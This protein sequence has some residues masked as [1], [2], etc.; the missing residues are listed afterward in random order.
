MHLLFLNSLFFSSQE[1]G[2]PPRQGT[3]LHTPHISN[4]VA[5]CLGSRMGLPKRGV[6]RPKSV[7]VECQK[8]GVKNVASR[9]VGSPVLSFDTSTLFEKLHFKWKYRLHMTVC[10]TFF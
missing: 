4:T 8:S 3:G 10:F 5:Y 2:E 6:F 1:H 9:G 7:G